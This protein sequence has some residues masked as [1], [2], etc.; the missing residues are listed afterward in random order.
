[1]SMALAHPGEGYYM[2]RD[3][4]GRDGDFI[5]APEVSQMFGELVGLWC[6]VVW[7]TMGFPKPVTLCELGPGRG[8]LMA[9]MLRAT[10]RAA[11]AFGD[12]VRVHLVETSPVLRDLQRRVV[13]KAAP[14]REIFWHVDLGTV[15]EG[16]LLLVANELFDALPIHQY[17][18]GQSEWRERR[19]GLD[20]DGMRLVFVDVDGVSPRL[21]S[22]LENVM[23]GSIVEYCP[24]GCALMADIGARVARSGGAALVIDYGHTAS[25]PG[26]TLQSLRRHAFNDV[27]DH[28]G[29]AD[30]TA[31]V[32]FQCLAVAATDSGALV[33]GPIEQ[34]L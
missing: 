32:D 22:T 24:A 16:P 27:L 6:V 5:T 25:A 2:R 15:P 34:G 33:Y 17:V 3:P 26:E 9:D 21:P 8:T 10:T 18:R 23:P 12:A 11:S 1:M 20:D 13:A 14:G 4:F 29:E 30:L 19:I 31:H 28:P 7:Q